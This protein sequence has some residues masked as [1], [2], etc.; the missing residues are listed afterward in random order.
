MINGPSKGNIA[1]VDNEWLYPASVIK[2]LENGWVYK[3]TFN[4]KTS[5]VK[6]KPI[7]VLSFL[8]MPYYKFIYLIKRLG[9]YTA[10]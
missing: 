7:Y 6:A 9:Y 4:S 5:T 3:L 8:R 1:M 10:Q 2:S